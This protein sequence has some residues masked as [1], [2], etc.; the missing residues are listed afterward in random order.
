MVFSHGLHLILFSSQSTTPTTSCFCELTSAPRLLS[1][2]TLVLRRSPTIISCYSSI[3][4]LP[5]LVM[6]F[7]P[8]GS[9][10]KADNILHLSASHSF[11]ARVF[12]SNSILTVVEFLCYYMNPCVQAHDGTW[13]STLKLPPD[14]HGIYILF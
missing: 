5:T 2:L 8:M 1:F 14:A 12:L 13:T 7:T 10:T 6:L 11:S 3:P 4:L 9:F